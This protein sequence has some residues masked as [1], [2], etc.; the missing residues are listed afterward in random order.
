VTPKDDTVALTMERIAARIGAVVVASLLASAVVTRA[1]HSFAAIYDRNAPIHVE[2]TVESL[3]WKNP[4][5][6]LTLVAIDGDGKATRWSFE[7]GAPRV[8]T[9]RFG[10]SNDVVRIGDRVGVEGFR[11]R[12]GGSQAAAVTVTT[13]TGAKLGAVLPLR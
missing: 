1:H 2:G 5:V 13:R 3:E 11:A 9:S 7:M 4:H 12:A 6:M 8:L 10:W